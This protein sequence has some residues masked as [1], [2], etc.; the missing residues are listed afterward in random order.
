MIA[1]SNFHVN[2]EVCG[3]T[4]AARALPAVAIAAIRELRTKPCTSNDCLYFQFSYAM[5]ALLSTY[6]LY[7]TTLEV[8]VCL[9]RVGRLECQVRARARR[10]EIIQSR[11]VGD[12]ADGIHPISPSPSLPPI[13]PIHLILLPSVQTQQLNSNTKIV[14]ESIIIIVTSHL[15]PFFPPLLN[16]SINPPPIIQIIQNVTQKKSNATPPSFEEG[17]KRARGGGGKKTEIR[18]GMW[19]SS[20]TRS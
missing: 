15:T 19:T 9:E 10:R 12:A 8:I 14:I 4:T 1:N 11:G 18:F 6:L 13:P 20:A 3:H 7:R 16:Q 5:G 17:N 2:L